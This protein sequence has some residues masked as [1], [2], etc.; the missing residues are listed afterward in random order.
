ML[1]QC[2]SD[3]LTNEMN[4]SV[5]DYYKKFNIPIGYSDHT[6]GNIFRLG[7]FF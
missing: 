6:Q 4:I 1:F 7:V 2:T 5:L 3:Y